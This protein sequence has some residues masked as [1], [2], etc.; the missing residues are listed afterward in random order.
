MWFHFVSYKFGRLILPWV[1]V[2]LFVS[3]WFMPSPLEVD[4]FGGSDPFL[5]IGRSRSLDT[6]R[7]ANKTAIFCHKDRCRDVDS[8]YLR[9]SQYSIVPP[10]TLWKETRIERSHL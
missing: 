9:D 2:V 6:R 8:R 4:C 5:F 1:F 3:S 10:K 7:T